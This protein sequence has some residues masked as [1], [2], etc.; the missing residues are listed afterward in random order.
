VDTLAKQVQVAFGTTTEPGRVK[1]L[2]DTTEV[3]MVQFGNAMASINQI[4]GDDPPGAGQVPPAPGQLP[5]QQPAAG[6]PIN[7][8][9]MRRRLREGL[10]EL[11]DAVREFRIVLRS[12]DQNLQN[13]KGFTEPLGRNGEQIA[14]S[15][16]EAVDGLDRLVE[17]FSV[18]G[19]ALNSREG[20]IGQLIHS[21]ELHKNLNNLTHNA[22]IVLAYLYDLLKGL[23]PTIDNLRFFTDKIAREPGRLIGGAFSEPSLIK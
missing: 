21:P 20:T 18:L 6:Q 12:A 11:P 10:L 13:L 15:I 3:A 16:V 7:G 9:Q 17:E 22:H 4:L 19:A 23:R 5:G 1:R 14:R 8:D 2:M